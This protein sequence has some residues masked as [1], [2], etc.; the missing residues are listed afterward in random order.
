M[1]GADCSS[2]HINQ[3]VNNE[4]VDSPAKISRLPK[5]LHT[6]R[7]SRAFGK[8]RAGKKQLSFICGVT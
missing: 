8:N 4:K 2:A 5:L 3:E 6:E 7:D 1:E